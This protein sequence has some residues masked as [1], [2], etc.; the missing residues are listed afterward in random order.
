[1]KLLTLRYLFHTQLSSLYEE[2][3]IDAIFFIYIEYKYDI[4]KYQYVLNPYLCIDFEEIDLKKLSKGTPIQYV[5]G[6]SVFCGLTILV[7]SSV[8]IPRQE[9][10]EMVELIKIQCSKFDVQRLR[11][12]DIGVGSGAIAI[13]LAKNIKN[14]EVLATDISISALE[15]AKQNA[16]RSNVSIR[17]LQHDILKDN[18]TNLPDNLDIIVSNPPYIPYN[19]RCDLHKNVVDYEPEQALFVPDENPL[20]FYDAI[21]N[22]AQKNLRKGGYLYFETYEKFHYELFAM[23][24]K[25]DF[26]EIKL[27]NDL[28]GK[29]RFASGKKL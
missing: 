21:S 20:L 4:K 19:K 28:N 1:M 25:K 16:L 5:T 29:P 12:L 8:L 2:R 18:A 22:V 10:E 26:K 13:A 27:W 7:N 14:A 6:E 11:I 24:A 17:F 15:T 3:E 9:T 23:L